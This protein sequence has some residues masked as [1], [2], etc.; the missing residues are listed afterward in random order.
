MM[1]CRWFP[2]SDG[3]YRLA[4]DNP[5]YRELI[6]PREHVVEFAKAVRRRSPL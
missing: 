2:Q 6:V 3:T 5:A 4:K 1:L